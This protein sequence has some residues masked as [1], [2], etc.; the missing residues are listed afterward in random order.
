[1][2]KKNT[3]TR[4]VY[5]CLYYSK[6]LKEPF[7]S[8]E[9]LMEAE[10]AYYAK[11]KAKEDAA[12]QKKADAVV[13]EEAFKALNAARKAY[14]EDLNE[15]TRV[16]SEGLVALK[17]KFEESCKAI[18][19]TLAAAEA[20]YANALKAFTDKYPEGYHICLKDGDFETTIS[21]KTTNNDN[22][23]TS[24]YRESFNSK[25]INDLFDLIF[26]F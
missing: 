6:V 17:E 3:K 16:Y 1:M 14:K 18:K 24:L 8:I 19:E 15:V 4:T 13:V 7:E 2:E 11:L 12:A 5:D 22:T 26:N 9:A 21:S 10:E 20:D 25:R 23:K